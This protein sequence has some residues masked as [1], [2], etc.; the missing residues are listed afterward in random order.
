VTGSML[1][2]F[3]DMAN[4]EAEY[5]INIEPF[6]D[7]SFYRP[8]YGNSMSPRYNSGDVVA[9]KRIQDKRVIMY[10]ETYLC[11]I[12]I[13]ADF[14]ETIKMLRKNVD[15]SMITLKPLNPEFDETVVPLDSIL[16]LYM[17]KGKVERSM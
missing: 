9:C 3:D 6:N 17:V 14:Y 4:E 8:V 10:G 16:E 1:R 5:Y 13:E 12:K 11:V 7:C 15:P 2:S